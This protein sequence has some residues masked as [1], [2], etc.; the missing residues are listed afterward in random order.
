MQGTFTRGYTL[1]E[2]IVA[3][4][5]FAIGALGLAA[6][7]AIVTREMATTGTRSA[8]TRLARN[9]QEAVHSACR[10]AQSG[11]E[12][13]GGIRSEWT[14]SRADSSRIR[15][16]GSVSYETYRGS[17]TDPYTLAFRCR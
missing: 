10:T 3:L 7:S 15:L 17:H 5:V 6:G 1:I 12:M 13:A 16:A 8:A 9:R 11:S 14:V 2:V 4:V